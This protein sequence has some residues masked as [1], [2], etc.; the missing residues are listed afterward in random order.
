MFTK[1]HYERIAQAFA[2]IA[3]KYESTVVNAA[4]DNVRTYL[5][6]EMADMFA[7]DNPRFDKKRFLTAADVVT[8]ERKK[9]ERAARKRATGVKT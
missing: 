8:H 4:V 5:A 3:G 1:Q 6:N 7:E 2:E 9:A